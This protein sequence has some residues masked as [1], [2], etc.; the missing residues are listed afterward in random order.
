MQDPSAALRVTN[1]DTVRLERVIERESFEWTYPR[2][3]AG[4]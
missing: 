1:V 2:R 3:I 4:F